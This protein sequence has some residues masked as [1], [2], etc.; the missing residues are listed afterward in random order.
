MLICIFCSFFSLLSL[1]WVFINCIRLFKEQVFLSIK[2][3]FSYL[4]GLHFD[5]HQS[6]LMLLIS[7]L[8]CSV[9]FLKMEAS[10]GLE[11]VTHILIS[12]FY[13]NI[14]EVKSFLLFLSHG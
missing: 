9:A 14:L 2:F 13:S 3:L 10:Y 5:F 7:D 1:T 12:M 4:V 8:V 11:V 6:F